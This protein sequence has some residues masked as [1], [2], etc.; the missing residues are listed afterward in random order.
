[1]LLHDNASSHCSSIVTD[2]LT[3]NQML[4]LQHPSYS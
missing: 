1:Q 4:L 3:K 2:S